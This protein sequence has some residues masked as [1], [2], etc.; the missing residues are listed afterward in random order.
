MTNRS[1]AGTALV[2]D[3]LDRL[4]TYSEAAAILNVGYH[5]IQRSARKG[6]VPTYRLGNARP[7]VRLRDFLELMV[8]NE[9]R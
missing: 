2:L 4:R 3:E 7:R 9:N 5:V 1:T 6:A 8:R